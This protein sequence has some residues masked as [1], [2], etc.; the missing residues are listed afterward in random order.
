MRDYLTLSLGI[1]TEIDLRNPTEC[2]GMT[3]SPAGGRMKWFRCTSFAYA[4]MVSEPGKEAFGKVFKEFLEEKN[5]PILFHCIAGQDRTG[6]VAFLLNALLGVEE[7]ELYLDWEVTGFWNANHA[8]NH[9]ERF[10]QLI[11]VFRE[12]PGKN[13]TEKAEAYVKSIGFS[14]ADIAHFR[15]LMLEP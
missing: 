8:F 15:S 1:H 5:Y 12:I 11:R 9:K 2:F 6:A 3:G 10:S 13:Y 7:E 4:D 14:D